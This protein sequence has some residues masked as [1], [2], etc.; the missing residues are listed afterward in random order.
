MDKIWWTQ[1]TSTSR[2]IMHV[3]EVV[4]SGTSI[5]LELSEDTP[6]YY[7]MQDRI[8]ELFRS[9]HSDKSL[10]YISDESDTEPGMLVMNKYCKPEI[11]ARFRPGIGYP[12]FLA[13]AEESNLPSKF[14][15]VTGV[16][17]ERA[18]LWADFLN[19]YNKNIPKGRE[20]AAFIIEYRGDDLT[21]NNKRKLQTISL[22]NELSE[23]DTYVFNMLIVGTV[24]LSPDMKQYIAEV[25]SNI[26]DNDV[27]LSAM[28]VNRADEF[29]K[30]PYKA[31]SE[32]SQNNYRSN[33]ENF[34]IRMDEAELQRRI[35]KAQIKT[36]F[37]RIETFREAFVSKFRN[38]I[39]PYLPISNP[40]G[41]EYKEADDVELGTL[42]YMNCNGMLNVTGKSAE[43]LTICHK[44]RNKL[45]HLQTLTQ[46][47]IEKIISG[48]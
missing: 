15:W 30:N 22:K 2:F 36:I 4:S 47:E 24:K 25:L 46:E 7:T 27:E 37:P 1:L 34:V 35:W 5:I 20:A 41:E 42:Y 14:V 21:I 13:E 23:Y 10:D 32:I 17:K 31:L 18:Q 38:K 44:A 33:G 45:A 9:H 6:W 3:E 11:R 12:K 19:D 43:N 26:V 16:T 8:D 28:C 48:I 29:L 40:L 39:Q